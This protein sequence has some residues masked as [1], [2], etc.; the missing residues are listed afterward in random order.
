MQYVNAYNPKP[1]GR[2]SS[3]C[4]VACYRLDSPGIGSWW[5]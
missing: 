1:V 4:I 5:G 3:V 2:D